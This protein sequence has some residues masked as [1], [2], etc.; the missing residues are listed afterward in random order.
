MWESTEGEVSRSQISLYLREVNMRIESA[1]RVEFLLKEIQESDR[2]EKGRRE[3]D[4]RMS[5]E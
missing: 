1:G 2:T 5:D 4:P 3:V